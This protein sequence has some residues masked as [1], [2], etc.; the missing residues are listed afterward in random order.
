MNVKAVTRPEATVHQTG[1]RADTER[2]MRRD[3]LRD[4][5][6]W[7][8][9]RIGIGWLF[10]WAFLDRLLALGFATG[11]DPETGVVDRFGDAAWI[12]GGSPTEGFLQSGLHTKDP[13]QDFYSSLAG[14]AW[15]DWIYMLSM[16]SI[17]LLLVLGIATRAAAIAGILWMVLF[18]T[19]AAIWPEHNPLIDDHVIEA[20]ALAGIAYVGAGRYLGLGSWWERIGLVSKYPLLR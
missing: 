14:H 12:N 17:G 15:V 5:V 3:R 2:F 10:L 13:F 20:I 6:F 19:A 18:Y 9:L 4:G 1:P 7:G 16:A 8:L 11:R